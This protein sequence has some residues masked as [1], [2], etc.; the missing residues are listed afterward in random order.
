[1]KKFSVILA[2][3]LLLILTMAGCSDE[4]DKGDLGGDPI[5]V[6]PI[7]IGENLTSVDHVFTNDQFQVVVS[8]D[9]G[10]HKEVTD[11]EIKE[12]TLESGAYSVIVKWRGMEGDALVLLDKTAFLEQTAQ[13]NPVEE[14]AEETADEAVSE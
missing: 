13:L 12:S 7:Y 2:A 14:T 5:F 1:M 8:Y 3:M 9:D 6:M 11:F 4:Y 10:T